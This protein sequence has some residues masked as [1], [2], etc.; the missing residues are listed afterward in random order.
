MN[1]FVLE[2]KIYCAWR[3]VIYSQHFI[4]LILESSNNFVIFTEAYLIENNLQPSEQDVQL[5]EFFWTGSGI[6]FLDY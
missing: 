5:E 1:E 6:T 3:V 4:E 2:R